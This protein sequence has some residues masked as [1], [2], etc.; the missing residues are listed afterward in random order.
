MRRSTRTGRDGPRTAGFQGGSLRAQ[1]PA[2]L[3]GKI[4][5]VDPET[6]LGW[7]G[8]PLL[9]SEAGEG[10]E[11]E[12]EGRIVAKGFRN[13]F[14]FSFNPR[15]GELYTDNVGSSEIEEIDRF[16]TPPTDLYNSGWPCYEGPERQFQ[17]RVLGLD[18]C[19]A[20]YDE[21]ELGEEPT[22][23][24]FF[25][26]SHG[27][28]AVPGDECPIEY[29]SALGG[30]A[31]YDGEDFP[32]EYEGA[33][34]FS[35]AVRGCVWVMF[36]GEDGR[37]DPH[38]ATR[39]M[40]ESRIYPAVDIEEGPD[41]ALYYADLY[42]NEEYGPGAIHRITYA[43]GA[44]TARL[45]A[46]PPYGTSL[47]L[48]VSFDATESSDPDEQAL[49]YDWDLDG[50][51]TFETHGGETKALDFSEEELEEEEENEESLNRVVGV[52]VTDPE[53]HSSVARVT[54]YPGDAPPQP[55]ID[56]P[57]AT[58]MWGVG[59]EIELEGSATTYD[60]GAGAQEPLYEPLGYYWSTRLL[61]CPTGPSTCHGHPL[62]I[63]AGTRTGEFEAPEHDYPSYIEITLRVADERGLTTSKTIKLEPRAVTS[64]IASS[65]PGVE[66]TAGLL[67]GPAPFPLSS[68]EGSHVLLS[69][70]ETYVSGDTTYAFSD[71]SDAGARIHTIVTESGTT[72][73]TAEYEAP[74]ARL[75]DPVQHWNGSG[76][77]EVEFDAS[78][79]T[80]E[81]LEYE[82]D[83]E[84]DGS[85]E[86]ASSAAKKT[87]AVG[88]ES[89]HKVAVRVTDSNGASDIAEESVSAVALNLESDPSGLPLEAAGVLDDNPIRDLRSQ[90]F[91]TRNLGA[92]YG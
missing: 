44:P 88:D 32:A 39:F 69:A 18:T 5:R 3:D 43:P 53:G 71:W 48:H 78:G 41:G 37:P 72:G 33:L 82:W 47:P 51:G 59:D 15:D 67:Q 8:N 52:R 14:R 46:N 1:N 64:T 36:P 29:G 58:D 4:L 10:A 61:H 76:E 31:F 16:P 17:F 7:P 49:E 2:S 13:P 30:I 84:G 28:S 89:P 86:V 35:D 23:D 55:E 42:G 54:V 57:L 45:S 26:Y 83:P 21:E 74:E 62:Q 6:G 50:N 85:F 27:Q 75:A 91:R 38:T 34:F 66:L 11:A 68:V 20:L 60:R 77:L 25:Y 90:G 92:T 9:G 79:S 19:E 63:F 65:P 87:I 40:R 22:A 12:N 80:G 24:P 81:D 73:Y 70:P 56:T